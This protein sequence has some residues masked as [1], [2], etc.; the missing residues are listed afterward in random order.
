MVDPLGPFEPPRLVPT[1]FV[2]IDGSGHEAWDSAVTYYNSRRGKPRSA[3]PR[4]YPASGGL[5]SGFP[6]TIE[7]GDPSISAVTASGELA[8]VVVARSAPFWPELAQVLGVD[9]ELN[10][11]LKVDIHAVDRAAAMSPASAFVLETLGLTPH[12]A[13][14]LPSVDIP[15]LRARFEPEIRDGKFPPTSE[16]PRLARELV[17]PTGDIDTD[18]LAWV[19]REE[20]LFRTYER[21]LVDARLR[22]GSIVSG[23]GPN[24]DEFLRYSLSLHQIRR[25]RAGKSFELH[26]AA[27][28]DSRGV[29]YTAQGTT[30]GSRR[31]DF[32]L[33]S[34]EA[35]DDPK[36]P[37]TELALL[38]A[39]RTCKDRWRQVL[40]EAPAERIPVKHICTRETAISASQLREMKD[41]GV[42]LV[43][44]KPLH[45]TYPD[46]WRGQLLS[47]DDF[48][49]ERLTAPH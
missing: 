7:V 15:I 26:I 14:A 25:S 23:E 33:P 16:L 8:V 20:Q 22:D 17:A 37:T 34:Q 3:E 49:R 9:S 6:G 39:K 19:D 21:I 4:L 44:P 47:L 32:L 40:N 42:R 13:P 30:E 27:A 41:S 45:A 31:P 36:V 12:V 29:R 24:V 38:A 35:Y 43:V 5:P 11:S 18:F 28:L 48:V 10:R 2:A 1:T 46:T